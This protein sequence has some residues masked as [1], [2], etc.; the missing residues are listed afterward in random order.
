MGQDQRPCHPHQRG[1]YGDSGLGHERQGQGCP[2]KGGKRVPRH[3][4]PEAV[5]PR[6]QAHELPRTQ[7][8]QPPQSRKSLPA[9]RA[10]EVQVLQKGAHRPVFQERPI[11]LLRLPVP[12]ETG[13]WGMR[14]SEAQCTALRKACRRQDSIQHLNGGQ[15]PRLGE[16]GGR[17]DGWS[18]CQAAH[19]TSD[20]RVGA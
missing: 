12:D 14:H 18:G 17:A 16:G 4:H 20:H 11:P 9:Q 6:F 10:G 3:R 2:G 19:Q 8:R 15:H 5:R 1:L 7:D 13:Q